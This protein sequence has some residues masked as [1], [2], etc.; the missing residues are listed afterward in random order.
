MIMN[1]R[2]IKTF[3][4]SLLEKRA[5]LSDSQVKFIES[6]QKYWKQTGNLSE[7]QIYILNQIKKYAL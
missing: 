4:N 3:F 6:V 1:K 2:E 5:S 7:K